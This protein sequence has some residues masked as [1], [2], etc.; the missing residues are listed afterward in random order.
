MGI[1]REELYEQVWAEPMLRVA[2]RYK[3]SSS[4]MARVCT[5]LNVP[6]P[7]VGY[8]ARHDVG[9]APPKQ[10]LPKALPGDQLEW[11]P[12]EALYRPPESMSRPHARLS[13][14]GSGV[15]H[16]L[17][18]G[19]AGILKSAKESDGYLKPTKRLMVD[20]LTSPKCIFSTGD[21]NVGAH[22]VPP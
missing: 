19:V 6:R 3:V 15:E 17:L 5:I 1:S 18:V 2:E 10:A 12:G 13:K 9:R 8:W 7:K 4:Y 22:I 20:V 16:A 14:A 21:P 11:T